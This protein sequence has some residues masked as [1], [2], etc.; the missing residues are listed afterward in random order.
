MLLFGAS[1]SGTELAGIVWGFASIMLFLLLNAGLHLAGALAGAALWRHPTPVRAWR[2]ALAANV[3]S[4]ILV[5]T[6]PLA[7]L[8]PLPEDVSLLLWMALTGH[9]LGFLVPGIAAVLL[10]T[11]SGRSALALSSAPVEAP[12]TTA[13]PMKKTRTAQAFVQAGTILLIL[14]GFNLLELLLLVLGIYRGFPVD[15]GLP[16]G[17]MVPQDADGWRLYAGALGLMVV[18]QGSRLAAG[19]ALV[20]RR[21][22]PWARRLAF[23][24]LG[25]A[26]VTSAL[27]YA[28][29]RLAEQDR[30]PHNAT[31]AAITVY[32]GN[33]GFPIGVGLAG[34]A[35]FVLV[36]TRVSLAGPT[37]ESA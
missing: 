29:V 35:L 14:G 3:S 31:M 21:P 6:S 28:V 30:L 4:M 11:K 19:I 32:M 9:A 36:R 27:S 8:L 34:L 26:F 5:F 15:L 18:V 23:A 20:Q 33:D 22:R 17:P 10:L 16:S 12:G 1:G 13:P 37:E 24:S 2:A 7:T 25:A